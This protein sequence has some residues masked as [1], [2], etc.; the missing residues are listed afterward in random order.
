MAV[1]IYLHQGD[2]LPWAQAILTDSAGTPVDLTSASAV[3]FVMRA[4]GANTTAIDA[5]AE[6]VAP[7]T[8]GVVRYRWEVADTESADVGAYFGEFTVTFPDGPQTFPNPDPLVIV[9]GAS[10]ADAPPIKAGD[11]AAIRARIGTASPPTDADLAVALA[12]LGS[13][14]AVALEVLQGRYADALAG[15]AKWSVEGDFSIDN[16]AVIAALSKQVAALE[17]IT[18]ESPVMTVHS[19]TRADPWR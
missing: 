5:A 15:P 18:G 4:I 8:A 11:L 12:R 3:R 6:V 9:I 19:L 10:V 14:D 17:T 13:A 7:A 1:D 16:T 2:T